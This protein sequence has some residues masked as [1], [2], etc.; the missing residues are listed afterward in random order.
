[1]DFNLRKNYDISHALWSTEEADSPFWIFAAIKQPGLLQ[2]FDN[3]A[4]RR[5]RGELPIEDVLAQTG[6]K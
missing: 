3:L 1:L 5:S 2:N 4:K 6:L